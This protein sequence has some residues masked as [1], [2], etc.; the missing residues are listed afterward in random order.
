MLDRFAEFHFIRPEWFYALIPL[1]LLLWGMW[2]RRLS[3]RNWQDVVEPRLLPYLLVG[4][5]ARQRPWTLLALTLGGLL[6]VVAMAG[7]AWKKLEVPV[8]RQP[9]ALVVLLDLSRS[10]DAADIRP[11]RLQRAQMKLRDILSQQKEGETALIVYAATPFVVSPL[12]SDAK[13]IASQLESLTTDIMPA[14][15]SRPDRAISMAQQLL[16]Q[17]GVGQG[18][19]LL[20]SDGIEGEESDEL[21]DAIKHLVG[22]G[23]R[24]S[25]LGV[26]SPEGAPIPV[27]EGG[28][29]KDKNGAIVLPRLDDAA[30]EAIARQGNGSYR[31]IS[32]DDSDFHATLASFNNTL[33]QL[34]SKKAEGMNSDQW[35]DEGHW[36]LLPLLLLGALAFRRGY[37]FLLLMLSLPLPRQAYAFDWQSLWQNSNQRA[38]QAMQANDPQQAA[39]LFKDPEWRA[40]ANYRAGNY[41]SAVEDLKEIDS[42]EAY[43]NRG[44]ALAKEGQLQEAVNAY[45]KAL[46]RNPENGDAKFNRDLVEELLKQQQDQ[47]QQGNG[48]DRQDGDG[49]NQQSQSDEKEH[50]DQSGSAKNSGE[51]DSKKSGKSDK[52]QDAAAGKEK[53]DANAGQNQSGKDSTA[54]QQSKND[55][56]MADANKDSGDDN[57]KSDS[58]VANNSDEGQQDVRELKQADRQWLQRIPDDPGGLWRRKFLYQ[59][60]QQQRKSEDKTW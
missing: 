45:D 53:T 39:E 18:G 30:L 27:A 11:S 48:K 55:Q 13:T 37:L 36:L 16:Q 49:P 29:L 24:L 1:V 9:S 59:Y 28:F 6:S 14:Q 25:V 7:P 47:Q 56:A 50:S 31:R 52:Q 10:M 26:G 12:T 60:Q 42:T 58:M 8:F 2:R 17:S 15:G 20:I 40:A 5:G 19:V 41:R 4:Q 34:Q 23:H 57:G 51:Q 46:K 21:K 3:S 35:R 38:Q 44:N 32:T 22:A 54:K 43:Y 33:V